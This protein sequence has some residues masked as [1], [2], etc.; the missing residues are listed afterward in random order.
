MRCVRRFQ[1]HPHGWQLI[2]L[3]ISQY[4]ACLRINTA[5]ALRFHLKRLFKK[6]SVRALMVANSDR[7]AILIAPIIDLRAFFINGINFKL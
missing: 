3:G 2:L 7:T 1:H 4:A 5:L 6:G